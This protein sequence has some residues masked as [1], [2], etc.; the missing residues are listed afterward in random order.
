MIDPSLV[1]V[2]CQYTS[3][4]LDLETFYLGIHFRMPKIYSRPVFQVLFSLAALI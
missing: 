2:L 1:N 4:N 3:T